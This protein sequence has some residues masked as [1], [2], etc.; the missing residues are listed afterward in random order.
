MRMVPSSFA[1]AI[2]AWVALAL[3]FSLT[4]ATNQLFFANKLQ[5]TDFAFLVA[6]GLAAGGSWLAYFKA[7]DLGSV[8]QVVAV[9]RLSL[10]VTGVLGF[11]LFGETQNLILRILGL[12]LVLLGTLVLSG[13][14]RPVPGGWM[15]WA[16]L[17][18]ALASLTSVLAKVGLQSV[19]SNL[20]TFIR[21]FVVA[22][23]A[24]VIALAKTKKRVKLD[25][26][27]WMLLIAGGLAT[28]GSWICYFTAVQ[29]GPISAVAAI[30][31]LSIVFAAVLAY[32]ALGEKITA[33]SAL[34]LFLV[35]AGT[36][37]FVV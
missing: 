5:G 6:S 32:L 26:K 3:V 8:V 30:D 14:E 9:D 34:G 22:L 27:T 20:G 23:F 13:F 1:T 16:L 18:M 33:R 19:P 29:L 15:V 7:L 35:V 24:S 36:L 11:T 28:G 17:S 31:K 4:L 12:I 37:T 25:S 2:R 21:T 10:L